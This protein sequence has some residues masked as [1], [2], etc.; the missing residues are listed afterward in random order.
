M[1]ETNPITR[2]ISYARPYLRKS[3][4]AVLMLFLVVIMEL[5]I[6]Q[7]IQRIIDQGIAQKD[8]T[9]IVNTSILLIGVAIIEALFSIGNTLLSLRVAQSYAADIRSALFHKV[10]S[11]SFSNMDQFTTGQLM[12]RLTSDVNMMQMLVILSLRLLIRAPLTMA[13]SVFFMIMS[14]RELA[15]IMLVMLPATSIVVGV[16]AAK[17]LPL[18]SLVQKKLDKLNQVLQENLAGVRIVKAF[19]RAE[20][21]SKRF[22]LANTDL[23]SNNI[24]VMQLLSILAPATFLVLNIGTVSIL[25]FGGLQVIAGTF[26]VGEVLAF[27]N[28]MLMTM[29]PLM[30]LTM[31]A[32]QISAAEASAQRIV[33]V[34]DTEIEVKNNSEAA[35]LPSKSGRVAFENV[36]F[37]YNRNI[38]ESVLKNINLVTEAGQTVAILGATGSGKS[39]LIHLISRFYDV[40]EGRVTFDGV[41][42]RDILLESLRAQVGIALQE[43]VLFSGTIRDNIRYGRPDAKKE[44]VISAAKI[45]QAHD[46]IMALPDGY[47]TL[48]GQRGVNL[49]G[50]EKQRIAIARAL[51]VQ[52]RVLILDDSTSSV[53]V[54]TE[55]K[56]Q[57]ALDDFMKGRT[58]FIVAQRIST[59]LKADKIVV[60][61]KGQI[62]AEGTHTELMTSSPIYREIYDSQLGNG[63]ATQ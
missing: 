50:G 2:L 41:D 6:P 35:P 1:I 40:T 53:D 43:S 59:V 37:S 9:V 20:H 28:Y 13:G 58:T 14:S 36:S 25:W 57:N 44:E 63:G 61:D 56:L 11:F 31:M 52:P 7:L 54:E 18:F 47:D 21:E 34:L 15:M 16:F 27:I 33:E 30:M 12:V 22:D 5:F 62:V 26:T 19:V 24:K 60:L 3:I 39:S 32:G 45:A 8:M 29:F 51:L 46:F 23:M 42:V 48:V 10:Q 55:I 4:L 38:S 49:S 17:A